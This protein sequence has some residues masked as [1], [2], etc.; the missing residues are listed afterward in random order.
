MLSLDHHTAEIYLAWVAGNISTDLDTACFQCLDDQ[1]AATFAEVVVH[2]DHIHHFGFDGVFDV[3]GNLGHGRRLCE[4]R[5]ENIGISLLGNRCGF[6]TCEVWNFSAFGR[7]HAHQNRARENW[8]HHHISA[9]VYR[10]ISQ[11]F[12]NAWVRLGIK[13]VVVN[14]LT[15]DTASGVDFFDGEFDTVIKIGTRGSTRTGEFHEA[16]DFYVLGKC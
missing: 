13:G 2:I 1:V 12:G 6:A 9:V 5:S 14:F 10:F 16:D 11:T 3:V 15:Q 7:S 8:A 4:R